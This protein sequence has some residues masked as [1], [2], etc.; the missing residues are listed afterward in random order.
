MLPDSALPGAKDVAQLLPANSSAVADAQELPSQLVSTA[1]SATAD[2][3]PATPAHPQH[4]TA[5]IG[6][7]AQSQPQRTP[8]AHETQAP[9][10]ESTSND[11]RGQSPVAASGQQLTAV[12]GLQKLGSNVHASSADSAG[13]QSG[14]PTGKHHEGDG[15]APAGQQPA[16]MAVKLHGNVLDSAG[17]PRIAA[18]GREGT[19]S[20]ALAATEQAAAV[21]EEVASTVYTGTASAAP[22][23]L[24]AQRKNVTAAPARGRGSSRVLTAPVAVTAGKLTAVDL[25]L[26]QAG[27]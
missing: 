9:S 10:S 25:Q 2:V 15:L 20:A 8:V 14:A 24:H 19:G 13:L 21:V 1:S 4:E 7:A 26:C 16:A 6:M 5:S 17:S 18:L 27:H 23:V 11:R 3:S 12:A 22:G